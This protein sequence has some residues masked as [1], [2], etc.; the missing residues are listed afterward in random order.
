MLVKTTAGLLFT[1][2]TM[3]VPKL[4]NADVDVLKRQELRAT[5]RYELE[6]LPRL[7]RDIQGPKF[8]FVHVMGPHEPFVFGPDG[9]NVFYPDHVDEEYLPGWL[10]R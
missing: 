4:L 5:I 3:A 9:E 10:S 8:V 1:D 6:T 7:P 2:A